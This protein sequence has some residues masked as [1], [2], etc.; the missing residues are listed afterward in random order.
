[1]GIQHAAA[2][3]YHSP[4][5]LVSSDDEDDESLG[6]RQEALHQDPHDSLLPD[7]PTLSPVDTTD[8]TLDEAF[9]MNPAPLMPRS[10]SSGRALP[11]MNRRSRLVPGLETA[12]TD[13]M[14]QRADRRREAVHVPSEP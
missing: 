1:M 7:R 11:L 9:E 3:L 13:A 14:A 10:M 2:G 6:K 5:P 12:A 8:M 4:D